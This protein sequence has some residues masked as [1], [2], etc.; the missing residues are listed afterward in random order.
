VESAA[1]SA[2]AYEPSSSSTALSTDSSASQASSTVFISSSDS[3][4]SAFDHTISSVLQASIQTS[5]AVV[6]STSS[7]PSSEPTLDK[8][9]LYLFSLFNDGITVTPDGFVL[10]DLGENG[11]TRPS[12]GLDPVVLSNIADQQR[13]RQRGL[14]AGLPS[15]EECFALAAAGL[16]L[17]ARQAYTPPP[18]N[19]VEI[20]PSTLELSARQPLQKRA[21]VYSNSTD[22]I[23]S[24][25]ALEKRFFKSLFNFIFGSIVNTIVDSVLSAICQ[26]CSEVWQFYQ[27]ISDPL[28]IIG[29]VCQ[30]CRPV[31]DIIGQLQDPVGTAKNVLDWYFAYGKYD[32]Q[33]INHPPPVPTRPPPVQASA[34]VT[35][36]IQMALPIHEDFGGKDKPWQRSDVL[37]CLDCSV[38]IPRIVVIGT[39]AFDVPAKK[40]VKGIFEI[41]MQSSFKTLLKLKVEAAQTYRGS[42]NAGS[43]YLGTVAADGLFSIE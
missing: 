1:T 40:V 5:S 43:R 15:D 20:L 31:L 16:A 30:P 17:A 26:P 18:N 23:V 32:P 14:D 36:Q 29:Q 3:S 22:L 38:N 19:I 8:Y 10:A 21:V 28:Y 37:W 4:S 11:T 34:Q 13:L 42:V 9:E 7:A 24:P 6:S 12:V 2:S 35:A 39:V 25:R 41:D 33:G 27:Q